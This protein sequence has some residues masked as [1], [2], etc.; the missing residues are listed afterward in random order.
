[1]KTQL[2][3]ALVLVAG[4]SPL[5]VLADPAVREAVLAAD[6]AFAALSTE[7]GAQ[8]GFQAYVA[9]D[10]IVF[11]PTAVAAGEWF[12]TH[13]Q[14]SGRLEWSPAAAAVDCAGGL[15]VTTGPWRYRNPEGGDPVAGH[16]LSLWRKDEN[17]E[18]S[19]VLDHGVDQE[20]DAVAASGLQ[21]GLDALWPAA[22]ARDC[23]KAAAANAKALAKADGQLNAAIRSKGIDVALRRYAHAW[24]VAYR[25]DAV[26]G[27]L[28]ADWPADGLAL[29]SRVQ[30]RNQATIATAGSDMGY[31]YGEIVEPAQRRIAPRTR[32]VYVRVWVHDGLDWRL[33]LD[34]LTPL[35]EGAGP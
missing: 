3:R 24:A 22:A 32:A 19:V 10:G 15:A 23:P 16:Y 9:S 30:G 6:T 20:R 13:E 34:M 28:A 14:A 12:A 8:Q 35:P 33:G 7:R 26:P 18:W 25:D 1:M 21:P 17:G 27:P 5:V 2:T 29:G 11:R 31:T 4:A